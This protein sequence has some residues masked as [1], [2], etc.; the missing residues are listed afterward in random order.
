MTTGMNFLDQISSLL[1]HIVLRVSPQLPNVTNTG[2][3]ED[4]LPAGRRPRFLILQAP[5]FI[6]EVE[7]ATLDSKGG[8]CHRE[9]KWQI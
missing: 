5:R 8:S 3:C 4:W 7:R 2:N 9:L 6:H 1:Q